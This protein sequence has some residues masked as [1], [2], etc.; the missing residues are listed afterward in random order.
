MLPHTH[1]N[2][3]LCLA[4]PTHHSCAHTPAHTLPAHL[5]VCPHLHAERTGA[6]P[7][8]NHRTPLNALDRGLRFTPCDAC[9]TACRRLR[10]GAP[11]THHT[12]IQATQAVHTH[13]P[14]PHTHPHTHTWVD[15]G[16]P[17]SSCHLPHPHTP[18]TY[19]SPTRPP[20][21]Y[22][23]PTTLPHTPRTHTPRT[24]MPSHTLPFAL[25]TTPLFP[26]LPCLLGSS[27]WV[28]SLTTTPP[29]AGYPP[30]CPPACH[31]AP[32]HTCL[33][34][35]CYCLPPLPPQFTIQHPNILPLGASSQRHT[36]SVPPPRPA[37]LLI[38]LPPA[39][40]HHADIPPHTHT[41]TYT[42]TLVVLPTPCFIPPSS[43]TVVYSCCSAHTLP[44]P[45]L[46]FYRTGFLCSS[47]PFHLYSCHMVHLFCTHYL[48]C[49]PV[50]PLCLPPLNIPHIP[51]T[52]TAFAHFVP[53]TVP[54]RC[55]VHTVLP[56]ALLPQPCTGHYLHGSSFSLLVGWLHCATA[57]CA[58]CLLPPSLLRT[59]A[60]RAQHALPRA[61]GTHCVR[62]PQPA[63]RALARAA[64]RVRARHLRAVHATALRTT[65]RLQRYLHHSSPADFPSPRCTHSL[66][67]GTRRAAR[68]SLCWLTTHFP[69]PCPSFLPHLPCAP[70]A[71]PL[72]LLV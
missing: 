60:H 17:P 49:D 18:H 5:P 11:P 1:T 56:S 34:P 30:P 19:S 72:V 64:A 36:G 31:L 55:A 41:H 66:P 23:L 42:H 27:S 4:T 38:P 67:A 22:L 14:A 8:L 32:T 21:P 69:L 35:A 43:Y 15:T 3:H 26:T 2:T 62:A 63:I 45:F 29:P 59:H 44:T 10:R 25:P 58:C 20:T 68:S 33:P 28:G 7:Y 61:A 70:T 71:H 12:T 46:L 47:F 40:T 37:P 6:V 53:H 51:A 65:L 50:P 48:D 24:Y 16:R 52:H 57:T 39:H 54:T 9:V 13:T